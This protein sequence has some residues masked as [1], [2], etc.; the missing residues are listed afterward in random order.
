MHRRLMPSFLLLLLA[1][2]AVMPVAAQEATPEPAD[3][4]FPVTI[5]HKFGS[6]TIEAA[7]ERVVS[8]G[9]TDHDALFA[10]GV[11]PV[12]IRYWYGD[13]PNAIFPWAE[14]EAAGATPEVL[15]MT[16][17]S[18][19]YEAILA[20]QPDLI[21]AVGAG[22][23]QEEYDLLSAIAPTVAQSDE[24]IDFGMPWQETT[25]MIAATVGKSAT[26]EA[27]IEEVET[28][29]ADARE[30]NP[31]L[32]GKTVAVAYNYG[33]ARTYGFYVS[34]DS[35]AR[36]FTELG[37]V[38]PEELEEI[39]GDRFYSD[40]SEERIDLLDQ[41][42]LVFLGLQFA[43]GGQ[44]AIEADALISQLDAVSEGHVVFVPSEYDD[45]LQF[46]TI[47]SLPYA[48]EGILPELQAIVNGPATAVAQATISCEQGFHA[49]DHTF[50][51]TDPVCIPEAPQRIVIADFAAF[52]LMYTLD[53]EPVGVWSLLLD[54][55]YANMVPEL[56][57]SMEAY[58]SNAA[59][60]GAI[61]LNL[62]AILATDPDLI[63]VNSLLVPD[64]ATYEQLNAIAPTVV[65]TETSTDDWRE[66][67]RFYGE[68]LNRMEETE[69]LLAAYDTR[70]AALI[71]DSNGAFA[72]QSA[73]LVQVNDPA[74]IYLSLPVY[75]GW[76]PLGEVGFTAS[77]QQLALAEELGT[78]DTLLSTEAIALLDTDFLILMNAA[79]AAEDSTAN[80]ALYE[81]YLTDPLWST[82]PALQNGHFYLVDLA[83]QANG[84][85]SAHAVIDDMYRLFLA[86][87]PSTPN[88][89]ADRIATTGT[90]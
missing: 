49:F 86:M 19:N 5:E 75:R 50:L 33:E 55:W 60:I 1:W 62:E 73:T 30:Q 56:L 10:L 24:Y 84:L 53:I 35:R 40:L 70:Q 82:L 20:L 14:D 28:L 41:D 45:A 9:F 21:I 57:P 74:T 89:Y 31:D 15:N 29:F 32:Q 66:Y 71:A 16:W 25:R 44:E 83:W 11:T 80:Q 67:M 39:A 2:L 58:V 12:A 17:G 23:T 42:I 18:L 85:I 63:L 87:E 4:V 46:S 13:A 27:L 7:P 22:I 77:E 54:G 76:L 36:F 26:A 3:D 8:I 88:P 34:Q 37:L 65:K 6:T 61:P 64:E 68:A 59:D 43:V 47:L 90:A 52:D 79:F 81:S 69:A 38:V 72:G 51:A 48:L 78:P